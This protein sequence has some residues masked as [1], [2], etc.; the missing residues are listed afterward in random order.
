MR[1]L[2]IVLF[3]TFI[4]VP[5]T[6]VHAQSSKQP[7]TSSIHLTQGQK[8]WLLATSAILTEMNHKRH[9]LLGGDIITEQNIIDARQSM[10][11]WWGIQDREDFLAAL[12]WIEQGGNRGLFNLY[13]ANIDGPEIRKF[14]DN[15]SKNEADAMAQAGPKAVAQ[16]RE[17]KNR[18]DIVSAH[19]ELGTKSIQ[20]WDFGRYVSLCRWGYLVGYLSE[21]EAWARIYAVGMHLQSVFSSWQDLGR[22]YL[23]GR[24]FWNYSRSVKDDDKEKAVFKQLS[25]QPDSPWQ[26]I[27]WN[28]NLKSSEQIN[29]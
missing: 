2:I 14:L 23:I 6:I 12:S 9:D 4:S 26:K 25:D 22:D 16:L 11:A 8:D 24:R 29:P 5:S 21:D 18:L 27:P 20:A 7:F 19:R 28:L 17:T 10:T 1:F 13:A 3:L 15:Y